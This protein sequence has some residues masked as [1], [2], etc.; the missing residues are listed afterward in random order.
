MRR[1]EYHAP[2]S[3]EEVSGLLTSLG[4]GAFILAGGTDLLVEIRERLRTVKHLVDIKKVPGLSGITCSAAQG[5]RFGA[6]TTAGEL[7]AHPGLAQLY[8]NLYD[9]LCALA[10]I[11][12]RNRATVIG[13]IC[14]AS[15]SADT[16]PPLVADGASIETWHPDGARIIP[17]A[18]FFT[19]PGR[20]VLRAGEIATAITVPPPQ[21]GSYRAYI[22][23]GRR[24][25]MELATVGV[26]V[27]L[28]TKDGICTAARIALGAVG[29]VVLRAP[30]A[31]ALLV[32]TRLDPKTVTS[33]AQQAMLECTPISNVRSSADYR[34]EMVGVLTR[35]AVQ[36]VLEVAA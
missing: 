4:D 6:M 30:Q 1:F 2:N 17:L 8:P 27:S 14:R 7:A 15:P 5:L 33:A 22:K 21:P 28:D 32:G 16:I 35:R 3:L 31:E 20:S 10:S 24:K 26:A 18:E 29:P 13:N 9:A 36:Q 34:R 25:A 11:Q 12:V 23:H 19:G